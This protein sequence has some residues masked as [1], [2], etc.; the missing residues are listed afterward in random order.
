MSATTT[1]QQQLNSQSDVRGNV[2]LNKLKI[3]LAANAQKLPFNC[4]PSL[5]DLFAVDFR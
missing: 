2:R 4:C 1:K 3:E 5:S